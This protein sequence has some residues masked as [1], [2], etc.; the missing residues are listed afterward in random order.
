MTPSEHESRR[1][2]RLPSAHTILVKRLGPAPREELSRTK[3]VG[4]GGCMF[5]SPEGYGIG[6]ALELLITVGRDVLRSQVR[7][8]YEMPA[9]EGGV[10]V[11]VEFLDLTEADRLRLKAVFDATG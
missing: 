7:V 6:S 3:V 10:E 11:G 8:V 1:Y 4:L 2:P 5:V 9:D